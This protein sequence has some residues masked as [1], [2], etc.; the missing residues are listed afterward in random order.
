MPAPTD[1]TAQV[2]GQFAEVDTPA[3]HIDLIPGD[4]RP[5]DRHRQTCDGRGTASGCRIGPPTAG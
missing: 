5:R 3:H 2:A 1:S 4:A